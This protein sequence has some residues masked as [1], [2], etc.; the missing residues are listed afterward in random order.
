[1]AKRKDPSAPPKRRGRPPGSASLTPEIE[2]S[3]CT[4]IRSGA[5]L[6]DAAET[7]G[8][9]YSTVMEWIRRGEGRSDR[10]NEPKYRH[11]ADA[12]HQAQ[13]QKRADAQVRIHRD[14]PERSLAL[15]QAERE[16]AAA[17]EQ[18]EPV[19]I[20]KVLEL[21]TDLVAL[22]LVADRT[23]V[24]PPC[25]NSRCRCSNERART[26]EEQTRL[27]DALGRRQREGANKER[28]KK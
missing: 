28:G 10:P 1:M 11:F 22:Q 2:A 27:R 17:L 3:I 23:Y 18:V 9:S 16:Q 19:S 5:S 26:Q 8:R 21:A 20:T 14:K 4:L 6:A 24:L 12:V 15:D 25:G 7:V 13:A